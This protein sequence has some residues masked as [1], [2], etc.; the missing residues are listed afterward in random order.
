MRFASAK[1]LDA[2]NGPDD[3]RRARFSTSIYTEKWW[4]GKPEQLTMFLE[5]KDRSAKLGFVK[6]LQLEEGFSRNKRRRPHRF[7]QGCTPIYY[8]LFSKRD[9]AA[10]QNT[11]QHIGAFAAGNKE[12][13]THR[14][15]FMEIE[16][17]KELC[18]SPIYM[19]YYDRHGVARSGRG[20]EIVDIYCMDGNHKGLKYTAHSA[21]LFA[22][23]KLVRS[24]AWGAYYKTTAPIKRYV[25]QIRRVAAEEG[26]MHVHGP[27]ILSVP[28]DQVPNIL[29]RLSSL[30][31]Y[32]WK[33][34]NRNPTQYEKR[35]TDKWQLH[36]SHYLD[37]LMG[38]QIR[39]ALS[40]DRNDALFEHP[41]VYQENC[42][43]S[44]RLELY[45]RGKLR[46]HP[47]WEVSEFE[48]Q[49]LVYE[50]EEKERRCI[51]LYTKLSILVAA[52]TTLIRKRRQRAV[53]TANCSPDFYILTTYH[54]T[55]PCTAHPRGPPSTPKN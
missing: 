15:Y 37:E 42:P 52:T 22:I 31:E 2:E 29:R 25:V 48:A 44:T 4:R 11:M 19:D 12:S 3:G 38:P 28:L 50:L 41:E 30:L 49:N 18:R 23:D 10:L 14:P 6:S 53:S 13:P 40:G 54:R 46:W 36:R 55:L 5:S 43:L 47:A 16:E 1:P 39:Y 45:R 34:E 32:Y 8:N 27:G 35:N 24:E 26:A 21:K 20:H 7:V 33:Y 17:R 9:L 51:N